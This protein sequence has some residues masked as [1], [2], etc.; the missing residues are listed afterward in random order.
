MKKLCWLSLLILLN[1]SAC[2]KN[3]VVGS[4]VQTLQLNYGEEKQISIL[5]SDGS[6][7]SITI[8]CT[9]IIENRCTPSACKSAYN[10][11]C[12]YF[13]KPVTAFLTIKSNDKSDTLSLRKRGCLGDDD[14]TLTNDV[15]D[16][17]RL[18]GIL[19][20]LANTTPFKDNNNLPVQQYSIKLLIQQP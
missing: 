5:S 20:G 16:K 17:K 4:P 13:N 14:L 18:N 19:I 12:Y 10:P 1:G 15:I 9:N 8:K 7:A 2:K 11:E 3:D 6:S